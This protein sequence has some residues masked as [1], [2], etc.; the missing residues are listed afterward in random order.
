MFGA[1]NAA[2]AEVR[3]PRRSH[4]ERGPGNR[5]TDAV[6]DQGTLQRG[7]SHRSGPPTV[8]HRRLRQSGCA[9]KRLNQRS[10]GSALALRTQRRVLRHGQQLRKEQTHHPRK[11][12]IEMLL[13]I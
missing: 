2:A 4:L 10:G 7:Y 13:I 9:L 1:S 12:L 6:T 11:A 8:D 3:D 5:Q